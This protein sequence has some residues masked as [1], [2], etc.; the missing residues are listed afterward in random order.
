MQKQVKKSHYEFKKYLS[1]ERWSSIWHQLDE[2]VE[3]SPHNVLEIGPGPGI[4]SASAR[5]IGIH[6]ETMDIDPELKPDHIASVFDIPFDDEKFD[7]VCA[8]QMLEH[9]PFEKSLLAFTEMCRVAKHSV[10][11]SLPDAAKR[12]PISLT[13]PRIGLLQ[14]SIPKPRLKAP[15]H[16]FDGEHYWEI[17]KFGY[18]LNDVVNALTRNRSIELIKSYRVN[19]NPYHHFFI[20]KKSA[21]Y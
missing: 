5:A 3:L 20:F 18:A 7:V 21:V 11:I 10:V 2:I 14:F 9:L 13:L 17:N 19:E 15:L 12:W 6:V 16:N 8:F 1:K 4:F